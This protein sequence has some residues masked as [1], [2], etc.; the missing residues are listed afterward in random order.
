MLRRTKAVRATRWPAATS[1]C[2][3]DLTTMPLAY[4]CNRAP[5]SQRLP[6]LLPRRKRAMPERAVQGPLPSGGAWR[7]MHGKSGGSRLRAM[8]AGDS[9]GLRT[10]RSAASCGKAV[11][12]VVGATVASIT[13]APIAYAC[14]RWRRR[15]YLPRNSPGRCLRRTGFIRGIAPSAREHLWSMLSSGADIGIEIGTG[16]ALGCLR[17]P[18][19]AGMLHHTDRGPPKWPLFR[20]VFTLRVTGTPSA[21]D[22]SRA[23]PDGRRAC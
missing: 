4:L 3:A 9:V 13:P 6:H 10:A 14:K 12:V 23:F 2:R 16:P 18:C 19:P 15:R 11:D 5:T 1:I 20:G 17:R 21:G 8:G 7:R 22:R